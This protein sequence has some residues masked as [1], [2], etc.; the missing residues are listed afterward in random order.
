MRKSR[1]TFAFRQRLF[2]L[3]RAT[4]SNTESLG[5]AFLDYTMM[6]WVTAWEGELRLKLFANDPSYFAEFETDNFVRADYAARMEGLSKAIA[7]RILSLKPDLKP[8]EI[9]TILY[10][11][12]RSGNVA[13]GATT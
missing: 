2:E 3:G 8:F 9:K 6:R 4:W 7:A 12:F 13:N 1:V 10:W 5:Q 11:L